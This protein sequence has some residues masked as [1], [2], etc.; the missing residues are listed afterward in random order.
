MGWY[1]IVGCLYVCEQ[2]ICWLV[3]LFFFSPPP[4]CCPQ[5]QVE[6]AIEMYQTLH[7]WEEAIVVAEQR[8]HPET[9]EMR[10]NYYQVRRRGEQD[11]YYL[12]VCCGIGRC[13]H[14]VCPP[15]AALCYA[16]LLCAIM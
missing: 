15:S 4:Y 9:Q 2:V 3:L 12:V 16:M 11:C 1:L 7:R 13:S 5:N 14:L 10:Q 8:Q 6:E